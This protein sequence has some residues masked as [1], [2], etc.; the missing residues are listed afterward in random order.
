MSAQGLIQSITIAEIGSESRTDGPS[1]SLPV[2]L[3]L[4]KNH[5]PK[6]YKKKNEIYNETSSYKKRQ[7]DMSTKF[8]HKKAHKSDYWGAYPIADG[9]WE[10]RL[11]VDK[12][13]HVFGP[14]ETEREAALTYDKE[15]ARLRT[16]AGPLNFPSHYLT[17]ST[18]PKSKKRKRSNKSFSQEEKYSKTKPTKVK[19]KRFPPQMRMKVAC[20][21]GWCCNFCTKH[22]DEAFIVDHMLPLM[23]QGTN[24][25]ETNIQALCSACNRYKTS[26]F[27]YKVLLPLSKVEQLT[28]QRILKLQEEKYW[29]MK[30]VAA[31]STRNQFTPHDCVSASLKNTVALPPPIPAS[32]PPPIA[33]TTG[34][35]G[36][37]LSIGGFKLSICK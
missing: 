25:I 23:L 1:P 16:R 30:C 13:E 24:C 21:Q 20:R 9:K 2:I 10:T 31:P 28:P 37:S 18:E 15:A 6:R 11:T 33:D 36:I 26:I 29:E 17:K 14:F 12:K 7:N 32:V 8:T 35:G 22:L 19:R 5:F 4:I 3:I 34:S 27:D